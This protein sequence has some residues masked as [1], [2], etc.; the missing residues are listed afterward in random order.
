MKR[1]KLFLWRKNLSR[2]LVGPLMVATTLVASVS[3]AA[4]ATDVVCNGCVGNT[5]LAA[6]SVD[7]T[8]IKDGSVAAA[9]L[10]PALLSR[11]TALETKVAAL[12]GGAYSNATLKGTY[13][14]VELYTGTSWSAQKDNMGVS[15]GTT[16]NSFIANG[17]GTASFTAVHDEAEQNVYHSGSTNTL[18]TS[19]KHAPESESGS[20]TYTVSSNGSF[21]FPT[22]A[23]GETVSGWLS[24]NGD[25]VIFN[26]V[27]NNSAD[28]DYFRGLTTCVR[29]VR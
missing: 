14:C 7:G 16:V 17:L 27:D 23:T 9:D 10:A 15:Y 26:Y 29:T 21:T 25:S 12:R 6:N 1:R 5:D 19:V 4:P 18:T 8:K 13:K 2:K 28:S 3:Q 20:I 11:I 24:P 22:G